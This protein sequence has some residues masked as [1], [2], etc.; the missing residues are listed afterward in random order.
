MGTQLLDWVESY[1]STRLQRVFANGVYSSYQNVTQGVPQGSVLGPLFYIIYANDLS[2][3]V[4][5][6]EIALYADDTVLF[7]SNP[8]FG[9]A[10]SDLQEDI[11]SLSD[12]CNNNGIMANTDKTKVMVFGNPTVLK[13][14][15]QPKIMLNGVPLQVVSEYK[16]LGVTLDNYLTFNLHVNRIIGSV[17]A[18]LKQFQRMRSFLNAKAALMVYKNMLL[19]MLEYGD[20]FLSATTCLNRKRLQ[21][22]QNKGLRCALNKDIET[23]IDDLH[24]EANVLKLKFRREQHLLNFMFDRALDPK[25]LKTKPKH[26]IV[27]RSSRKRLMKLKRP[28]TEKFKKSLA[29][30]GP[31]KWNAL[32]ETFHLS[33]TKAPYKL[34]VSNMIKAKSDRELLGLVDP[35]SSVG[36]T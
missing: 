21:I 11:N 35:N 26:S 2:E 34:L 30:R 33:Q 3:V 23:S 31:K 6:C 18:K 9:K 17:T 29:Y 4:K 10:T 32:P 19:P 7:T 5:K 20:V 27:T 28:Y 13:K 16:Y 24:V 1:L 22:I 25:L 12:W 15:S 36:T 8:D 14:V